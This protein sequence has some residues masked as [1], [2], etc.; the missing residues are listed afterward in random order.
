MG[1]EGSGAFVSFCTTVSDVFGVVLRLDA[2]L[3]HDPIVFVLKI[4]KVE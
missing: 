1:G 3:V 4:N 2:V